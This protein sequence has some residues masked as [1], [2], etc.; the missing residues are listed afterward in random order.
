MGTVHT[1]WVSG[2]FIS[3]VTITLSSGIEGRLIGYEDLVGREHYQVPANGKLRVGD[4][5][6]VKVMKVHKYGGV[7]FAVEE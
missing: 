5:I 2:F 1:G 4:P 7:D 3:G 6:R